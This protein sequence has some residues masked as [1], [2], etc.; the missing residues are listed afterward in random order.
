MM[1][2]SLWFDERDYMM[3]ST[4][5]FLFMIIKVFYLNIDNI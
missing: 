3:F 5:M 1:N 2:Y 4:E